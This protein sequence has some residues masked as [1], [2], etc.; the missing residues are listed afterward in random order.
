MKT[1]TFDDEI[2]RLVPIEWTDEMHD[3]YR[4]AK[5]DFIDHPCEF[6]VDLER[7]RA[8]YTVPCTDYSG[9]EIRQLQEDGSWKVI[10]H[11]VASGGAGGYREENILY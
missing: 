6:Q 8:A 3:A 4:E 11:T 7:L 2:F 5:D 9:P 10:G 1:V